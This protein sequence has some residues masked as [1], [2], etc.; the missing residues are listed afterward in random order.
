M[1][2]RFIRR[3]ACWLMRMSH[4][5]GEI[6]IAEKG[7]GYGHDN[8]NIR[9]VN[10]CDDECANAHSHC[11]A[12]HLMSNVTLNVVDSKLQLGRW[13]RIIFVELDR[14]RDRSYQMLAMGE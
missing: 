2:K 13:Q 8:M 12:C 9:T 3:R 11:R 6:L 1:F 7:A 5:Y 4:C 14:P 10:V